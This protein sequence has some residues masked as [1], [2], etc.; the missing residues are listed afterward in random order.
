MSNSGTG[1]ATV[2]VLAG[3]AP[4]VAIATPSPVPPGATGLV[5]SIPNAG[6]GATYAWTVTNGSVASGQGTPAI[7]WADPADIVY[8]TALSGVQLNASTP[9][10]GTFS[11]SPAAGVI[12]SAGNSQ[13]LVPATTARPFKVHSA[14]ADSATTKW[15]AAAR[16][17]WTCITARCC[18]R[19]TP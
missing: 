5:A 4:Q 12:L 3:P 19:P 1:A 18:A 9:V 11:Y 7:T 14:E 15:P 16:G 10:A 2:T 17:N 8:G 13:P 6:P